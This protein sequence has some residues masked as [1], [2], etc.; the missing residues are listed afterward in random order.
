M[1]QRSGDGSPAAGE[2]DS[3]W[4]VGGLKTP[5]WRGWGTL[6]RWLAGGEWA[7][8]ERPGNPKAEVANQGGWAAGMRFGD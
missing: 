7:K 4:P 6:P 3:G 5:K 1:S 8:W 2:G